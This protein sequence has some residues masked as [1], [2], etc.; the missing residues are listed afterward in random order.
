MPAINYDEDTEFNAALR[1]H[2]IIPA[3][4]T[5]SRSPSPERQR[6]PSPSLSDLDDLSLETDDALSRDVLER[7][8]AQRMAEAGV[9]ERNRRFGRVY[10][11]GKG[12]YKREVTEASL[13]DLEGEPE[14]SGT[15]TVCY[16][17]KD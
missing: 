10:P 11:I 3:L 14:G 1:Q 8:R 17:F 6:T 4:P 5:T 15:G 2:G 13:E 9:G 16:L 12:D 7:Y